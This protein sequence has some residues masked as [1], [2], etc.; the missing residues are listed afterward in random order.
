MY[1]NCLLK[2]MPTKHSTYVFDQKLEH[3]DDISFRELFGRFRVVFFLQIKICSFLAQD[4][5]ITLPHR[6]ILF[7]FNS[8]RGRHI[9]P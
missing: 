4:I 9:E 3:I 8:A 5:C 6:A 7:K 2:N 1:A